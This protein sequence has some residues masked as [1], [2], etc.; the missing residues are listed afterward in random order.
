[1]SEHLTPE[2]WDTLLRSNPLEAARLMEE[3]ASRDLASGDPHRQLAGEL[4]ADA[5]RKLRERFS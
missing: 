1:M 4:R 2:Q 5:A 3:R